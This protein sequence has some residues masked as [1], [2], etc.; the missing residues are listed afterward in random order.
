[1]VDGP[2]VQRSKRLPSCPTGT[3]AR[4]RRCRRGIPVD[5]VA[6]WFLVV[7]QQNLALPASGPLRKAWL[8]RWQLETSGLNTPCHELSASI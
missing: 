2:V 6:V 8:K 4:H 3:G 1:M 5:K 7:F